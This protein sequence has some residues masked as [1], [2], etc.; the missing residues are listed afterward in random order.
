MPARL[1]TM[2][3]TTKGKLIT[4]NTTTTMTTT[5]TTT[6]TRGSTTDCLRKNKTSERITTTIQS[7]ITIPSSGKTNPMSTI[8]SRPKKAR[9]NS[10]SFTTQWTNKWQRTD[11]S[12]L[13]NFTSGS[14]TPRRGSSSVIR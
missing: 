7:T 14:I 8:N 1:T 6:T 13:T 4:A 3:L 5:T 2:R 10:L 11:S 12:Q 9:R